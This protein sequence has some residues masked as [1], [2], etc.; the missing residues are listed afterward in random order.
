MVDRNGKK[1]KLVINK[2]FQMDLDI[3]Q[4]IILCNIKI[5]FKE[6]K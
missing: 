5:N 2:Y 6:I 1:L 3:D 4:R